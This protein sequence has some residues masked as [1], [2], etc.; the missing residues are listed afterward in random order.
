MGLL[1]AM[2]QQQPQQQQ[3]SGWPTGRRKMLSPTDRRM[4]HDISDNLSHLRR[5]QQRPGTPSSVA[6][7]APRNGLNIQNGMPS[8][9]LMIKTR[10]DGSGNTPEV[11]SP[12]TTQNGVGLTTQNGVGSVTVERAPSGSRVDYHKKA[13]EQ[14]RQSLQDFHV[15]APQSPAGVL[16]GGGP[17][18]EG[19]TR[20]V[21]LLS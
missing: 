21:V 7:A 18:R 5:V 11:E 17:T 8:S 9:A 3:H 6:N 1:E 15:Q 20:Q 2:Q 16:Y 12:P 13:M 4:L 14:I 19:I 10:T